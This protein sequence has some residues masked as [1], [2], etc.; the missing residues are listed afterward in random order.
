M[1]FFK[2][3]I[4]VIVSICTVTFLFGCDTPGPKPP[5]TNLVTKTEQWEDFVS[6]HKDVLGYDVLSV[7]ASEAW[8]EKHT[9]DIDIP[10]Q[11]AFGKPYHV[12]AKNSTDFLKAPFT[13][14]M[15]ILIAMDPKGNRRVLVRKWNKSGNEINKAPDGYLSAEESRQWLSNNGYEV[16][17]TASG[18]QLKKE[19]PGYRFAPK[20]SSRDAQ[21]ATVLYG[22]PEGVTVL[23]KNGKIYVSE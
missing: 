22:L 18:I 12:T 11:I 19:R 6:G 8:I 3:F 1:K 9:N 7:S 15:M 4:F 5:G 16:T 14:Y 2:F 23:I 10:E 21:G 20:I 17:D 13:S